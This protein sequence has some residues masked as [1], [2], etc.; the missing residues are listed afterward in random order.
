MKGTKTKLPREPQVSPQPGRGG[1]GDST[2]GTLRCLQSQGSKLNRQT[3]WLKPGPVLVLNC[4]SSQKSST[5]PPNI[6]DATQD[7]L[8]KS[9]YFLFS[10][11]PSP[12]YPVITQ[13]LGL[14]CFM[15]LLSKCMA[16]QKEGLFKSD[17]KGEK[18]QHC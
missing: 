18:N 7:A 6:T 12:L 5:L 10:V 13:S 1:G 14:E 11:P 15:M 4:P 17:L 3:S 16:T 8:K 2:N 9:H